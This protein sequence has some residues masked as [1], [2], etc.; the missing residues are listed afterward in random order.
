MA[1]LIRIDGGSTAPN[2]YGPQGERVSKI[3]AGVTTYFYWGVGEKVS[4]QWHPS[5]V[6]DAC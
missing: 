4:G 3:A 1:D 5:I 2:A 6:R